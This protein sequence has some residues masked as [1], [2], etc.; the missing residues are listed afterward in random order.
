MKVILKPQIPARSKYALNL[1]N[2]EKDGARDEAI[3]LKP[4]K[5]ALIDF[6]SAATVKFLIR[7]PRCLE[8]SFLS[9]QHT[10]TI[11]TWHRYRAL[12]MCGSF[13]LL[14]YLL[15]CCE[16][17]LYIRSPFAAT[18]HGKIEGEVYANDVNGVCVKDASSSSGQQGP[19]LV[20]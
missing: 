6:L 20:S 7:V 15:H 4:F 8:R 11:G 16:L 12:Y 2:P 14:L 19:Y 17:F 3:P 5:C 18:A 13:F 9:A 10:T 1:A